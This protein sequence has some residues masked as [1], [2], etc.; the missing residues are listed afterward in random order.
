M[1]TCYV[2]LD[3]YVFNNL[4][5]GCNLIPKYKLEFGQ[6]GTQIVCKFHYE[7]CKMVFTLLTYLRE[8]VF[9]LFFF[10]LQVGRIVENSDA[11]TEILNN[12]ELLKQIVFCI[13]AENLSVAKAVS[14]PEPSTETCREF[15]VL[16]DPR[17]TPDLRGRGLGWITHV[18]GIKQIHDCHKCQKN[19]SYFPG[20]IFPHYPPSRLH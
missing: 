8:E 7:V 19:L 14:L 2:H 9:F 1:T 4:A 18:M 5:C 13:G 3:H 6:W 15:G 12:A 20:H 17:K 16:E 10:P 11:V